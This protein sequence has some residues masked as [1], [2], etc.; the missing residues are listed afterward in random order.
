M[1]PRIGLIALD[2]DGTLLDGR[3]RVPPANTDAV[4]EAAARGVH[5]AII[6]GRSYPFALPVLETLPD[7]LVLVVHNGAVSRQRGGAT[8]ERRVLPQAH[9]RDLLVATRA[10]RAHA[11]AILDRD[12]GQTLYDR[13]SWDHP[14]RR[15]YLAANRDWIRAVPDLEHH[16][17]DTVIQV[18]FN[19]GVHE[20][21]AMAAE[22]RALPFAGTLAVSVTEYEDRDFS[23]VDVNAAE[24]T[25]GTA[26][27]RLAAH[28]GVPRSQVLAVGDN[29]NDLDM[30]QWAGVGVVMGNAPPAL[31]AT[32]LPVTGTN[33][34]AGVA[35]VIRTHVLDGAGAARPA[36][37][38]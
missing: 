16:I 19:G 14:Q 38:V 21:R 33:D 4:R 27:A 17:D 8:I 20:M 1:S 9:A 26:L 13:M 3:G 10:W 12:D 36:G 23:L 22:V 35:Q 30:L 2:I 31:K 25:K 15:G 29:H 28:L 11:T 32:G 24:T 5:V 6:T 18:A 37:G 7:P 34:E